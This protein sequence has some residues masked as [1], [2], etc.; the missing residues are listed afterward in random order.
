MN[1]L[2]NRPLFPP[3]LSVVVLIGFNPERWFGRTCLLVY[4]GAPVRRILEHVAN[5]SRF[6]LRSATCGWYGPFVQNLGDRAR[7]PAFIYK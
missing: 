4:E 6:P 3:C 2:F 5:G 1:M 7:A